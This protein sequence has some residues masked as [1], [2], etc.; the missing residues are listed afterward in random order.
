M[1]LARNR[2]F[3]LNRLIEFETPARTIATRPFP[4]HRF[5]TFTN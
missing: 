4:S 3:R 1:C 2:D 5:A